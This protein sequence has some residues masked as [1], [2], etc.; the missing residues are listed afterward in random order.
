MKRQLMKSQKFVAAEYDE[1]KEKQKKQEREMMEMKKTIQ[2]QV[3]KTELTANYTR[4][5]CAQFCNCYMSM[6]SMELKTVSG[7]S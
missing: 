2:H 6:I 3:R 7:L 1:I 5:D 4:L